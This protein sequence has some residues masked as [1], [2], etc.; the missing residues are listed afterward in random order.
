[1][2]NI[3]RQC[4]LCT[5]GWQL[6]IHGDINLLGFLISSNN[7]QLH[8]SALRA[9][10]LLWDYTAKKSTP[11]HTPNGLG[12]DVMAN[13]KQEMLQLELY[14]YSSGYQVPHEQGPHCCPCSLILLLEADTSW[15]FTDNGGG[16]CR[17]HGGKIW[18]NWISWEDE[19]SGREW[20]LENNG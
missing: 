16:S 8:G 12:R 10:K 3:V 5:R 14:H 17:G 11:N 20:V 7:S 18:G 19:E 4:W 15:G 2:C 1:M 6:W 9:E 13:V